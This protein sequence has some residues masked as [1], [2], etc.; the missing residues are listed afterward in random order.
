MVPNK[1]RKAVGRSPRLPS[2]LEMNNILRQGGTAIKKPRGLPCAQ[3]IFVL[4]W[5]ISMSIPPV[6]IEGISGFYIG[7]IPQ[8][9]NNARSPKNA[10][11]LD[12][13]QRQ[14]SEYMPR[15]LRDT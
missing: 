4:S 1:P 13:P 10:I 6:D 15:A 14:H 5:A 3:V 12:C 7:G 8:S 9:Q 2:E 11:C